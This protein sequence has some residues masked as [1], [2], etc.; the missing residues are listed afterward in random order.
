MY[1]RRYRSWPLVCS[2]PTWI[3]ALLTCGIGAAELRAQGKIPH[4]RLAQEFVTS[5]GLAGTAPADAKGEDLLR[6]GFAR[7]DLGAFALYYPRSFLGEASRAEAL[8]RCARALVDLQV[9][10]EELC[11]PEAGAEAK[12]AAKE[13]EALAKW[14]DGWK[15]KDLASAAAKPE[16]AVELCASLP[17]KDSQRAAWRSCDA[18][19]SSAPGKDLPRV[20][21]ALAPTRGHFVAFA[22]WVGTTNEGYKASYWSDGAA[23]WGEFQ[24][25]TEG[26]LLVLPLENASP[27]KDA[28]YDEGYDM[29]A[30]SPTGMLQH[31]V[32]RA[33]ARLLE[34]CFGRELSPVLRI[35][36]SQNLV[37][38]LYGENNARSG[39]SGKSKSTEEYGSFIPGGN[40]AGGLLP[41][42]SADSR[43]RENLG[44]DHFVRVLRHAQRRGAK[45]DTSGRPS[46]Q[47]FVLHGTDDQDHQ[48][49]H[50]PFLGKGPGEPQAIPA[51]FNDDYLEFLRA[52]RSCFVY[53]LQ[54]VAGGNKKYS[55]QRF[56]ELLQGLASREPSS[57]FDAVAARVYGA[58]LRVEDPQGDALELR[59]LAWLEKQ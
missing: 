29:N 12:T 32:E 39:G 59:F 49:V 11:H 14:I 3:A 44:Q 52:Y 15:P 21:L 6:R 31:V 26:D 42:L 9:R 13:A 41:T 50:A 4:A 35:G 43:F 57:T 19:W 45:E 47:A 27:K 48:V 56:A 54:H 33:A 18:R 22:A 8:K 55:P 1:R 28:P 16:E 58:P 36:L 25:E 40:S 17:A 46:S 7:L 23:L 30:K 20:R 37:I 34:R 51:R 38:D 2:V 5:H 24:V 10:W 53:W